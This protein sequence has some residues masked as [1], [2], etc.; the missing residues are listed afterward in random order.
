MITVHIDG[1]YLGSKLPRRESHSFE[2]D[3]QNDSEI[4]RSIINRFNQMVSDGF[5]N[6]NCVNE[7]SQVDEDNHY[8][9]YDLRFSHPYIYVGNTIVDLYIPDYSVDE[10][11]DMYS[12]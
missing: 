10:I 2:F 5:V 9:A 6:V 12:D 1:I 11:T 8:W 3:G 4:E 7:D